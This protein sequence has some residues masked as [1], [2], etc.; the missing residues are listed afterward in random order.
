MG[1]IASA[2]LVGLCLVGCHQAPR[3]GTFEVPPVSTLRSYVPADMRIQLPPIDPKKDGRLVYEKAMALCPADTFDDKKY[4]TLEAIRD[5]T[6]YCGSDL[7]PWIKALDKAVEAARYGVWS[8]GWEGDDEQEVVGEEAMSDPDQGK[9]SLFSARAKHLADPLLVRARLRVA[10]GNAKAS[11]DY[12]AVTRI[13]RQM[14]SGRGPI[15]ENLI[16]YAVTSIGLRA[17]M[18]DAPSLTPKVLSELLVGLPDESTLGSGYANSMRVELDNTLRTFKSATHSV[19]GV[20][21]KRQDKFFLAVQSLPRPLEIEPTVKLLSEYWAAA[22]LNATLERSKRVAVKDNIARPIPELP[23][24]DSNLNTNL[25]VDQLEKKLEG[26][27]NPLGRMLV[28]AMSTSDMTDQVLLGLDRMT[29]EIRAARTVIAAQLYRH[30]KGNWPSSLQ[31]LVSEGLLRS[32]PIDPFDGKPLR[33]D[34]KRAIVWSVSEDGNDEGG[35]DRPWGFGSKY[36]DRVWPLDG[37]KD[38]R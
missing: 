3:K 15:L 7:A 28:F 17:I 13:G 12:L 36:K 37:H 16:G 5:S 23:E 35:H 22:A 21:A 10:Q 26:V 27:R 19:L 30:R 1:R 25:T 31:S 29:A 18:T 9:H 38:A 32:V 6:L 24:V 33:Y 2:I 20:Y 14:L 8:S 11:Q 4:K 34:P